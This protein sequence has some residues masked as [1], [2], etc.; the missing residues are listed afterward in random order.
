M[1]VEAKGPF[2]PSIIPNNKLKGFSHNKSKA[3]EILSRSD[4]NRSRDKLN[5]LIRKDEDSL[6]SKITEYILED[7]KI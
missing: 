2:P 1:G 4:F 7:L 6:F 5:I 3:K